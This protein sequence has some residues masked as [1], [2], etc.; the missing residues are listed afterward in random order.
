MF[1][2]AAPA[3]SYQFHA[4]PAATTYAHTQTTYAALPTTYAAP[5]TTA[6]SY[7]SPMGMPMQQSFWMTQPGPVPFTAQ[8]MT[9]Q[10]SQVGTHTYGDL[11]YAASHTNEKCA[12]TNPMFQ[13]NG[14]VHM[15]IC[16]LDYSCDKVSWAS[17]VG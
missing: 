14:T 6:M 9:A 15:F 2:A 8:T 16:G 17:R 3:A 10:G 11:N 4:A 12:D 7:V 5:A 1:F 13:S